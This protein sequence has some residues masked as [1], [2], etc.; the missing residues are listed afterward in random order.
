MKQSNIQTLLAFLNRHD[1]VSIDRITAFDQVALA[2]KFC[3]ALRTGELKDVTDLEIWRA[4][5]NMRTGK[6]PD[7]STT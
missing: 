1:V 7:N 2:R 4:L 6:Y 5:E 3:P